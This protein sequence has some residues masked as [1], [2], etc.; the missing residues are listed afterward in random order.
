VEAA[1]P[2]RARTMTN[3]RMMVF[4]TRL[5][6]ADFCKVENWLI[7]LKLLIREDYLSIPQAAGSSGGQVGIG[8]ALVL[9]AATLVWAEAEAIWVEA[10]APVRARTTTNAR[11]MVFMGTTPKVV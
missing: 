11:M 7:F 8:M 4:M 9:A 6:K 10:A 1:A 3:A 5:P 2:V